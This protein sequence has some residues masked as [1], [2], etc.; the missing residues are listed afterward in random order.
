MRKLNYLEL[1]RE[2]KI[3]RQMTRRKFYIDKLIRVKTTLKARKDKDKRQKTID[4][5]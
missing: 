5:E 2:F 3:R 1:F 4:T